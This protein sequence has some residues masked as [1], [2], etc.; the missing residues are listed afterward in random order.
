MSLGYAE[1]LSFREDLGGQIGAPE[2]YDAP[3]EVEQKVDLLAHLVAAAQRIVVFTGAGISTSCG[4]PDFRGPNGIWTLQRAGKPLPRASITFSAARP[5]FTHAALAHLLSLGK[6]TYIVSQN[7]DGLHLRSGIPRARLAELHGNSFAERCRSC[8]TE[9]IRDFEVET[10][11]FK[12]TGRLCT[13]DG[14]GGALHDHVLDWEDELP[15]DELEASGRHAKHADLAICLGT[16]LQITPACNL[17][18]KTIRTYKDKPN[19][20]KLVIINLQRTQHDKK[21]EKS[22]G[23]VIRAKAD[24]VMKRLITKLNMQLPPFVREDAICISHSWTGWLEGNCGTLELGVHSIHGRECLMPMVVEANFDF[25][26][27]QSS[28]Q[29]ICSDSTNGIRPY[30]ARFFLCS[31]VERAQVLVL[32]RLAEGA[33]ADKQEVSTVHDVDLQDKDSGCRIWK[34]TTQ[35]LHYSLE[36]TAPGSISGGKTAQTL[37]K[38]RDVAELGLQPEDESLAK[39]QRLV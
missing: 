8:G 5:S 20:G 31:R 28:A 35:M 22:G 11:G 39:K 37:T 3:Q 27:L 26:G 6:V 16:S 33:D 19:P 17:P 36:G 1:K 14:C 18:L 13:A 12:P 24:D 38:A 34:F 9:Y 2:C 10:V 7:V 30:T 15:Q 23:V 32:L 4:I 29:V 25:L 21:A